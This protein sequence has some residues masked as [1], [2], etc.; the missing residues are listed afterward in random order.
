MLK[1][2]SGI[3]FSIATRWLKNVGFIYRQ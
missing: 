2:I 3:L 1:L